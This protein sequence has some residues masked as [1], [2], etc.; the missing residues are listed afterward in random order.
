MITATAWTSATNS[1]MPLIL[2]LARACC[3]SS[4]HVPRSLSG[5]SWA[6]DTA[7]GVRPCGFSAHTGVRRSSFVGWTDSTDVIEG[8]LTELTAASSPCPL[9]CRLLAAR[10]LALIGA[11]HPRRRRRSAPARK[12][13]LVFVS[14]FMRAAAVRACDCVEL[15]Q[16]AM[17][18]PVCTDQRML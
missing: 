17:T 7:P 14:S 3:P 4:V 15:V 11:S 10:Q 16:S 9:G 12:M 1:I 13:G 6:V 5:L 8:R 2:P 18:R